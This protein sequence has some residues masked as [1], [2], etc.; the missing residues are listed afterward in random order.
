MVR[1][2]FRSFVA[3]L[4]LELVLYGIA[5]TIHTHNPVVYFLLIPV[6]WTSMAVA[7]VHSA[8][9][10]SFVLGFALAALLYG[11]LVWVVVVFTSRLRGRKA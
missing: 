11:F 8:G 9:F 10:L 1:L 7:G 4:L 6:I 3:A 2:F 5:A